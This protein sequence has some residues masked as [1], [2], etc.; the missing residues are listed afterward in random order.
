MQQSQALI[1]LSQMKRFEKDNDIDWIMHLY[2]D[3]K[4]KKIPGIIPCKLAPG[5]G[6]RSAYHLYALRYIKEKFNNVPKDKFLEALRAEGIPGSSGYG[7]Q[8]KYEFIEKVLTSKGYKRLYSDAR[9]NQWREE[10]VLPGNDQLV[11]EAVVFSQSVL[12]RKQS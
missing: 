5:G 7:A 12:V 11:D 9:L 2:L 3:K 8:N 1:L 10:N 4:L 6:T